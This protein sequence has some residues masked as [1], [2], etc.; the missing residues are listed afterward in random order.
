MFTYLALAMGI[1]W[2]AMQMDMCLLL[3]IQLAVVLERLGRQ[4]RLDTTL[5]QFILEPHVTP[6]QSCLAT[7]NGH[8]LMVASLQILE[9]SELGFL[10]RS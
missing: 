6:T 9:I 8:G 1:R 3:S 4:Y 10:D 7:E 2:T 5:R